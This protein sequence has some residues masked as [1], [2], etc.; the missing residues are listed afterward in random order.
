MSVSCNSTHTE[1][2][3]LMFTSCCSS[4]DA[5]LHGY[6]HCYIE[7][8]HLLHVFHI[9]NG[10]TICITDAVL[11]LVYLCWRYTPTKGDVPK[12]LRWSTVGILPAA[13]IIDFIVTVVTVFA[14]LVP[15]YN[16]WVEDQSV[17][18]AE[19]YLTAWIA[20]IVNLALPGLLGLA[21]LG[22]FLICSRPNQTIMG[23]SRSREVFV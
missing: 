19:T 5:G 18:S 1:I 13:P 11:L 9:W 7:K 23:Q 16:A 14:I 6:L 22:V 17:C 10:S 12:I 3:E 21:V 8:G 15:N 2:K 20:S 4:G